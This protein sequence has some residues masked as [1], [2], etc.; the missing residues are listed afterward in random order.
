MENYRVRV[1]AQRESAKY[2]GSDWILQAIQT[3]YLCLFFFVGVTIFAKCKS[4]TTQIFIT[5]WSR[6]TIWYTFVY[7]EMR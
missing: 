4:E 2:M 3:K 6:S 5:I 1:K 7:M